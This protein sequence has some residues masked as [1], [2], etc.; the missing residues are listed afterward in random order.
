[1]HD[2]D[3]GSPGHH[4]DHP[5]TG[6]RLKLSLLVTVVFIVVEV[7]G[8]LKA[9]SLALLSDAGHNVTDALALLL[10][11]FAY[12]AETRPPNET[13]TYGYQRAGVLSAFVNALGLIV[14]AGFIFYE[15]YARLKAPPAVNESIMIGVA[16]VGFFMNLGIVLALRAASHGDLNIRSAVIHQFGDAVGSI[17]II[18]GGVLMAWTGAHWIDPVLS[19]LIGLLIL[20]TARDIIQESLNILLEGLPKGLRLEAV[21]GA[22]REVAGVNDVHD[23]HIWSLAS[24][25]H[26]LSCHVLIDDLP[27]SSSEAILRCVNEI[28]EQ[29]FQ[30]THTTIQFEHVG[31]EI[32][33]AGCAAVRV[34]RRT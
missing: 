17:G 6:A 4:H 8:G 20:W 10:A 15:S 13:K 24:H 16:A 5:G 7:I 26:A 14:L 23:I 27:P 18:I 31:C 30:I 21:T 34:E 32:S 22:M 11:W 25:S 12:Y 2:H 1:L 19:I 29:R 9:Q 28:L 33:E 3:H